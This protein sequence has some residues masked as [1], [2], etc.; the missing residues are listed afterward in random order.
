MRK[1]CRYVS[2]C[3]ISF[4]DVENKNKLSENQRKWSSTLYSILHEK[5]PQKKNSP[6]FQ[7]LDRQKS[8]FSDRPIDQTYSN[9]CSSLGKPRILV[10]KLILDFYRLTPQHIV[11]IWTNYTHINQISFQFEP[12]FSRCLLHIKS[13]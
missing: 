6:L 5:N 8:R 7:I 2:V 11:K 4:S 13:C 10:E 12:I 1:Q 3:R 9:I